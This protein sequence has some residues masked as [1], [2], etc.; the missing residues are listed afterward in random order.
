MKQI[1]RAKYVYPTYY[2]TTAILYNG[3]V[4][5]SEHLECNHYKVSLTSGNTSK[6]V[7]ASQCVMHDEFAQVYFNSAKLKGVF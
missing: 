4:S 3:N 5:A 1:F 2:N 6:L 7:A